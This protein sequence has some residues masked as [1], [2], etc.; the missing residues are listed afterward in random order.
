MK[1]RKFQKYYFRGEP[2]SEIPLKFQIW[3]SSKFPKL[4]SLY[5]ISYIG[6]IDGLAI[7]PKSSFQGQ[8]MLSA[9]ENY[10]K[11]QIWKI[12][13]N[14]LFFTCFKLYFK[15]FMQV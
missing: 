2:R 9:S 7:L 3:N 10:E 12:F 14:P 6:L 5:Y 4:Y 11:D 13:K 8:S 15:S 1:C